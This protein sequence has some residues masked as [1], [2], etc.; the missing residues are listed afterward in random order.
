MVLALKGNDAK[1]IAEEFLSC[2]GAAINAGDFDSFAEF[3]SFPHEI[4]TFD[5]IRILR[6]KEDMRPIFDGMQRYHAS[7]GVTE[8]VRT[9]IEASFE[10]ADKVQATHM[11]RILSHS[12]LVQEPYPAFSVIERIDGRW[13]IVLTAY[14][15]Q[16]SPKHSAILTGPIGNAESDRS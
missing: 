2:T 6:K 4:A 15:I 10:G 13:L 11:T 16:D 1:T 12:R 5:E 14:A 7:L 3:F 8:M 9:V